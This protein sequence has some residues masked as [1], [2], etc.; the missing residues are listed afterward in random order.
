MT[1][2]ENRDKLKRLNDGAKNNKNKETSLKNCG[3]IWNSICHLKAF[4]WIYGLKRFK[5]FY[6]LVKSVLPKYLV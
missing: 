6:L 5:L 3:I 1:F 2:K 4:K